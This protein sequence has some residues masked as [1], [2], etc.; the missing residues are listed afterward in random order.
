[1]PPLPG[2]GVARIFSGEGLIFCY[3]Y[4]VPLPLNFLFPSPWPPAM[5]L[6]VRVAGVWVPGIGRL[7]P[8]IYSGI[9]PGRKETIETF[10][11]VAGPGN[12]TRD[13]PLETASTWLCTSAREVQSALTTRPSRRS[14]RFSLSLN[15]PSCTRF[16][17][18]TSRRGTTEFTF[19]LWKHRF[20]DNFWDIGQNLSEWRWSEPWIG[21][22][23][24][25]EFRNLSGEE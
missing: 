8:D 16:S 11:E 13:L 2:S 19:G 14:T 12:R 22:T 20:R 24:T 9:H 23:R 1:M 3:F 4:R 18:G 7:W 25:T 21:E 10:L 15:R 17:S 6:L 5:D